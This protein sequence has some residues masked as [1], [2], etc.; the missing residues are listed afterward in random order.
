MPEFYNSFLRLIHECVCVCVL[1]ATC[2]CMVSVEARRWCGTFR[3][4][5]TCGCK[6]AQCGC[7]DPNS[8]PL[9]ELQELLITELSLQPLNKLLKRKGG[10][11]H[12][13]KSPKHAED[14]HPLRVMVILFS[15]VPKD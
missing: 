14:P 4:R 5:V 9:E 1:C 10:G 13:T 3:A 11:H 7:W 2:V 8:A 12:F 15:Y 6:V